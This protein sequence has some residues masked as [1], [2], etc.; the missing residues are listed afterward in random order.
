MF[1]RLIL[2]EIFSYCVFI[3]GCMLYIGVY[4]LSVK[5]L[6][7]SAVNCKSK[8]AVTLSSSLHVKAIL[9]KGKANPRL[10]VNYSS[11][12]GTGECNISK[13]KVRLGTLKC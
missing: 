5:D 13:G 1:R 7:T 12:R 6:V 8:I 10:R 2:L 9:H 11:C 4:T 3:A